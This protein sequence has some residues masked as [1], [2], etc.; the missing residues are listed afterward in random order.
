MSSTR[1]SST[2][3]I[4][5]AFRSSQVLPAA[6]SMGRPTSRGSTSSAF[7]PHEFARPTDFFIK[8]IKLAALEKTSASYTIRWTFSK[9][10]GTVDLYWDD[11]ALGFDGTLI[12]NNINASSGRYN[13]TRAASRPRRPRTTT[14]TRFFATAQERRTI[15]IVSTPGGR[16]SSTAPI[17]RCRVSCSTGRR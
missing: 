9:P 5:T 10:S 2:W 8:R 13:W 12:Q 6:G 14:S 11:D 16:S 15:R 4:G 7:D 3:R 1:S 17:G